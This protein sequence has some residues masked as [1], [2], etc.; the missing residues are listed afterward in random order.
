MNHKYMVSNEIWAQ[1][2]SWRYLEETLRLSATPDQ[3]LNRGSQ[4]QS[5]LFNG[6]VELRVNVMT[7]SCRSNRIPAGCRV[8]VSITMTVPLAHAP[9]GG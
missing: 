8:V 6:I 4:W 1:F 7:G 9:A 2:V 5:A 3:A